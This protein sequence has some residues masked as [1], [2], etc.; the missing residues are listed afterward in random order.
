MVLYRAGCVALLAF[1]VGGFAASAAPPDK[2]ALEPIGDMK[3]VVIRYGDNPGIIFPTFIVAEEKGFLKD[4]N[5]T[6]EKTNLNGSGAI[7]EA[8]AAGNVDIGNTTLT[9]SM[10]ATA[11]GGRVKAFAGY[12]YTFT[13]KNGKSWE[14]V[15][16]VVRAGEGIKS[17]DDLRGKRIA[18][19]DIGSFYNYLIREHFLLK[20]E[21]PDQVLSI[22]PMPFSQMAGALVQKQVDAMIAVPDGLALARQRVPVDIIGTQTTL[23]QA[24]I[25]I[26]AV[27]SANTTFLQKHPDVVARFL[28]ANLRARVF[29]NDSIAA[30]STEVLDI[31]AA[32]TKLSKERAEFFWETRGGYYGRELDQVNIMDIPA[33]SVGLQL[34]LLKN[35]KLVKPDLKADYESYIDLTQLRRAYDSLG[36][37]W[38]DALH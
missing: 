15:Y 7:A 23:E 29:M 33:N 34:T 27:L 37:K 26:S 22:I 11:K 28:R 9:S 3:P 25:G 8:L 12:E 19:N 30:K 32:A 20:G 24:P 13:E 2:P 6:L 17:L 4:E 5:I 35:A 18:V 36:L 31:V 10:L 1:L 14:A 21:N 16:V 38:D